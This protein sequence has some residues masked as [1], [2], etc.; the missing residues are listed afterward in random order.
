MSIAI[1]VELQSNPIEAEVR[2]A[3]HYSPALLSVRG[4]FGSVDLHGDDEQFAV[5]QAAIQ[6]YFRAKEQSA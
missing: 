3:L 6:Q 4:T 1:S 5:I 2:P